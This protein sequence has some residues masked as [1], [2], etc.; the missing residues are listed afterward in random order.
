MTAEHPGPDMRWLL[1]SVSGRMSRRSYMLA[2]LFW[3]LAFAVPVSG[4]I[5]A[6]QDSPALVVSG[7]G[8]VVVALGA[9]WSVAVMSIRRLHDA[10]LP[11]ILVVVLVIPGASLL[12]LFITLVWPSVTGPNRHGPGPDQPGY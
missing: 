1:F 6:S 2:L 4:A 9:A 8:F 10:G 12:M 7:L 3:S 5:N 11:G